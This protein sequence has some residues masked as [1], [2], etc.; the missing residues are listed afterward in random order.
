M[1]MQKKT[2]LERRTSH[3]SSDQLPLDLHPV[4]RRIYLARGVNTAIELE[5]PLAQLAPPTLSNL[6]H[7][8]ELLAEAI[9]QQQHI[10]IVGD[11]DADGATGTAV[12]IKGLRLL[13]AHNVSYCVPN[14]FNFGYGLTPPLVDAIVDPNNYQRPDLIITVD[15]GISS[16]SGVAHA[17]SLGIPTIITDHHLPAEQLPD[18]AAI[19]NPN[20]PGD[21]FPSKSLAGVGVMFYL[22]SGIR[23]ALVQS[24]AFENKKPPNLAILLDLVALG[25]VADMVPLDVNNRIL[26][27]QGLRRIRAGK[28]SAGIA[29]LMMV[30]GIN[31]RQCNAM[32]LSWKLAPRLNAAGRLEDMS[33][34]IECLLTDDQNQADELAAILHGINEERRS[35][36]AQMQADAD[37]KIEALI[38]NLQHSTLSNKLPNG[39]CLFDKNWHQG[40][41][42]LVAGRVKEALQRPVIALAPANQ[43]GIELKGSARSV[44]G[45]HIRDMLA[46]LDANHPGL[47]LKFGGHAMA[48]GLS[49]ET[50]NLE[51]FKAAWETTLA[52]QSLPKPTIYSDGEL[53]NNDLQLSLAKQLEQ[54]GPWGQAF[55]EPLFDGKFVVIER[56]LVGSKHVKLQLS[57]SSENQGIDAIA[58]FQDIEAYP[59]NAKLHLAYKLQVN[60]FRG[61]ES[62]QLLIEKIL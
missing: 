38:D 4:L 32:D 46:L 23:K 30:S 15:N 17:N 19:V 34:G 55:P 54:A 59:L 26:V 8:A 39:I 25:T 44:N 9:L 27:Q 21:D 13:G 40:V 31:Q 28:A 47:I 2:V 41:V 24:K 14:R 36:Q 22:L 43:Q 6:Q 37:I 5:L 33:I 20:L 45:I 53:S 60:R 11:F 61:R 56:R 18:A 51:A 49:L 3:F 42:G 10:I 16:I 48:A 52:T 29:A 12:A 50:N 35:V 62:V 57:M 58:F 1:S 7:A